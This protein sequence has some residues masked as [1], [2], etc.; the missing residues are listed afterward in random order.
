MGKKRRQEEAA[1]AAAAGGGGAAAD[2]ATPAGKHSSS[3]KKH[4]KHKKRASGDGGGAGADSDG[5]GSGR[6]SG[7]RHPA[8]AGRSVELPIRVAKGAAAAAGGLAGAGAP[9]A[10]FVAY[11]ANGRVPRF[12]N[13]A[14]PNGSPDGQSEPWRFQVYERERFDDVQHLVAA[15]GAAT[16]LGRAGDPELAAAGARYAVAVFD[17]ETRELQVKRHMHN[18]P[19]SLLSFP[20]LSIEA[21]E[22]PWGLQAPVALLVAVRG[23]GAC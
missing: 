14:A 1:A 4:K 22:A 3:D 8:P 7:D 18:I 15:R 19:P 20:P 10:P 2:G 11:F 5:G 23:A 13:D 9:C 16:L 6:S 12:A 21:L 17:K